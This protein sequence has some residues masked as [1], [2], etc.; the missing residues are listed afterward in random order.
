MTTPPANDNPKPCAIC[1]KP[2]V[3]RYRPFCSARCAD[4]DLHRW[5]GGH[6]AV[7]SQDEDDQ[8]GDDGAEP[9]RGTP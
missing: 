3:E 5:L 9:P 1:G 7:P 8:S 2:R 6:Y 4:I